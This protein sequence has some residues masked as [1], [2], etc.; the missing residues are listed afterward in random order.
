MTRIKHAVLFVAAV[1]L[2]A[3]GGGGGSGEQTSSVAGDFTLDRTTVNFNAVAGGA[4]P[5]SVDIRGRLR[6]VQSQV[7]LVVDASATSLI[8]NASI[9]LTSDNSG[10]LTLVPESVSALAVGKHSGIVRVR[11]CKT[12]NCSSEYSGSPITV[13][14]NYEVTEAEVGSS[15]SIP[16]FSS[17]SSLVSTSSISSLVSSSTI[18]SPISSTGVSSSAAS[19]ARTDCSDDPSDVFIDEVCAPWQNMSAYEQN[20]ANQSDNYMNTDSELSNAVRYGVIQSNDIGRNKVLDI[21]FLDESQYFAAPQ[22]LAPEFA[23]NG[24]D[25]SEYAHGKLV[26]DLKVI[27]EAPLNTPL[28]FTIECEWP[29]ASTPE[30]LRVTANELNKWKTYEFSVAEM[31]ERGLDVKRL[32]LGFMLIPTFGRQAGAHYQLDNIRWVKGSPPATPKEPLCY[33][34]HFD[35]PWE[36]GV[37][38]VGVSLVGSDYFN[39]PYD[40]Q[41]NL[42]R[43]VRPWVHANP[44]WSQMNGEWFYWMSTLMDYQTLELMEPDTLSNCSGEGVLSLEIYTSEALVED[45]QMTFTVHFLDKNGTVYDLDD[46]IFSVAD[47]KP[48]D[49][50]KLE[51]PLTT[52]YSDLKYVGLKVN[53]NFVSTSLGYAPFYIDNIL[54]KQ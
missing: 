15:S 26:F 34:N 31:I 6:N 7:Y 37:R 44:D 42:T 12:A 24:F 21:R 47:M 52:A 3:C 36:W 45:G 43:F 9:S 10:V 46:R 19:S 14:I 17:P 23:E 11:A 51:I 40:Q 16:S 22:I 1:V 53:A 13:T 48:G 32:S 25:M 41:L 4:S 35:A 8:K 28:E 27:K 30:L 54:I 33:A 39:V 20:Y 49:W 5:S 38:G 29:C 50:N 2:T 18:S